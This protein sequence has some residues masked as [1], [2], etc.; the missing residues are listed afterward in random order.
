MTRLESRTTRALV[1][2]L[3]VALVFG[4]V[5]NPASAQSTA[6]IAGTQIAPDD[7]SLRV[8][9]QPDGT[10]EWE[11]EYR[12]RLDEENKTEAFESVRSD[13]EANESSYVSDFRSR[14]NATAST[15]ENATG[16]SMTVQNVSVS[17]SRQQLPQ[18][19]GII[20]Y[21]FTWTNFAAVEDGR[22][23]AGDAL[24]GFFL[25]G[26]T[27][28]LMTW[29]EGYEVES[30]SPGPDDRRARSV[31][32]NGPL[33]FGPGEPTLL[34]AESSPAGSPS[35]SETPT[36]GGDGA[37]SQN[38]FALLGAL[39][40]LVVGVVSGGGWMLYRRYDDGDEAGPN[41]RAAEAAG[42]G[43]DDGAVGGGA[44]ADATDVSP[45]T[46]GSAAEDDAD[47]DES[48]G[49]DAG[50]ESGDGAS[51]A[52]DGT[53]EDQMPWEDELLSN[54]ECVLA[55]IEHEGGRLKQQ[56]VAGTLDWTDAK[57]SQVVR[58]MRDEGTLDAFRLGRENVLVLPDDDEDGEGDEDD[59]LDS[60]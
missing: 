21:S 26:E 5:P 47:G 15:A 16:R 19:Y 45:S 4:G 25:D 1:V 22:I 23:R 17:T 14:M 18:E 38:D 48:G 37:S 8:A 12:V 10:A 33:D 7:V 51:E 36:T 50:G 43:R 39:G 20:T 13:I 31:V 35:P 42:G 11:V 55:L 3:A 52:E 44:P 59:G 60:E 27:S 6:T 57:T 53:D 29:P 46:D 40:L 30:V 32:W 2:L 58:R 24:A 34:L 56:E 41:T 54:E 49:D 28:L 9:L